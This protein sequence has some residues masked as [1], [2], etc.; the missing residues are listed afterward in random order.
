MDDNDQLKDQDMFVGGG[1]GYKFKNK[2]S[3]IY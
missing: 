1:G 3:E 2:N